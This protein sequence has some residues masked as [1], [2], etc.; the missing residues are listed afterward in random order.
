M[1]RLINALGLGAALFAA[2]IAHADERPEHFKG[3][4]AET[5]EVAV[6]NFAE[7]NER[8]AAVLAAETLS[9][10][11]FVTIHE[12]TY[13]IENALGRINQEVQGLA[14]ML[15]EIHVASE[16]FDGETIGQTGPVY[17]RTAG[18]LIE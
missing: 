15:E 2:G 9:D 8:L 11:D 6:A 5:L 4:P 13:T 10:E 16:S 17:L 1:R 18:Q 14:E 7:Y 3:K 12:L